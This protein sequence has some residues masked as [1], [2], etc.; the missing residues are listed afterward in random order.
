M[1]L[2]NAINEVVARLKSQL[3]T[4]TVYLLDKAKMQ[5]F[6]M[7]ILPIYL[8]YTSP[9]PSTE[10][11]ERR[12]QKTVA[13]MT[14]CIH[15]F[16]NI[17]TDIDTDL[18]TELSKIYT[19]LMNYKFTYIEDIYIKEFAIPQLRFDEIAEAIVMLELKVLFNYK[20]MEI[21]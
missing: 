3:G 16:V 4:D 7:H 17:V 15:Y 9:Y 1:I 5:E 2:M 19:A 8:V 12:N 20:N 6:N 13:N 14:I 18:R 10:T 11:Y 21:K